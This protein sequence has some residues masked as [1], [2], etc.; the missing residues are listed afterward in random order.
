MVYYCCS[1]GENETKESRKIEE[2]RKFFVYPGQLQLHIYYA[3]AT[4]YLPT[5][6]GIF[7]VKLVALCMS[8]C[9]HVHSDSWVENDAL[10]D[11]AA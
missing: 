8:L 11:R 5:V 2:Q 4:V 6:V 9:T 3:N 7:S 1:A 10:F